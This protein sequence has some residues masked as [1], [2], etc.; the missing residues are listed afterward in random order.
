MEQFY[1][2]SPK[3][4]AKAQLCQVF[5][6]LPLQESSQQLTTDEKFPFGENQMF[7]RLKVLG[8]AQ[9][10]MPWNTR[11]CNGGGAAAVAKKHFGVFD[12]GRLRFHAKLGR[13]TI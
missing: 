2:L 13:T 7:P 12:H 8:K 4:S 10:P 6:P 5:S 11:A 1:K 9:W 3:P